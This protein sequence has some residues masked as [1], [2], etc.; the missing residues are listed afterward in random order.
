MENK[1]EQ[2]LYT[3]HHTHILLGICVL[4]CVSAFLSS[5][6]LQKDQEKEEKIKTFIS[7]EEIFSP[8][9]VYKKEAFENLMIKASA[10]VVYD[11]V[12]GAVIAGKN[13]DA[14]MPLASIKI[15]NWGN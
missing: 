3:K 7:R 4:F 1:E 9:P 11:V 10:Y 5:A 2:K 12:S 15:C 8:P 6:H 13:K 14:I